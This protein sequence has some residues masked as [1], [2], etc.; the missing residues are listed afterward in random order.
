MF[1]RVL[2]LVS[3][4]GCA[5][6]VIAA[7][8][9]PPDAERGTLPPDVYIEDYYAPP[10]D[11]V[12]RREIAAYTL[13]TRVPDY[14]WLRYDGAH[15]LALRIRPIARGKIEQQIA[16]R[17]INP[18]R[19][20]GALDFA[21]AAEQDEAVRTVIVPKLDVPADDFIE[22]SFK[23]KTTA[24]HA[25]TG[26]K[27]VARGVATL[28]TEEHADPATACRDGFRAY[29]LAFPARKGTVL[30]DLAIVADPATAADFEQEYV[31]IDLMFRRSAPQSRF[32]D[33]PPR[34]WIRRA[35][36]EEGREPTADDAIPDVRAFVES[37]ADE[38]PSL[39]LPTAPHELRPP[40]EKERDGG[41]TVEQVK[42]PLGDRE[43]GALRITLTNGPR[44]YLKFPIAFDGTDYNTL[45]FLARIETPAGARP[46]LGDRKPM[47]WGTDARELNKP[48][49]TFG[50]GVYSATH[51]FEDWGR[52][53]VTQAMF[54]Q[55]LEPAAQAPEGWRVFAYDLVH[56]TPTGNKSAFYPA[57]T[58][59]TFYYDNRKIPAGQQVV[60]TLAAPKVTSGLM[61]AGGDLAAY[62]KFLDERRAWPLVSNPAD[63]RPL[64]PPATNRLVRPFRFIEN[65][66][67]KG[68]VYL[69]TTDIPLPYR[70]VAR[71]AA[72]TLVNLLE[73][74]HGTLAPIPLIEKRP[75]K[76]VANAVIIG[77]TT[78]R[79]IDRAR[80]TADLEALQGTPGCAIRSDGTN[81]YLYA[82]VANY[83]GP[84]RGL[85][86][87]VYTFLENNTDIIFAFADQHDAPGANAVFDPS[88]DGTFDIVWGRDYLNV[89]P[90]KLWGASG[91]PAW[92]NDH[93][94]AARSSV[95]GD[96]EYAGFRGRS[97]NHWWGYGTGS[98]GRKGE[99]NETWGIGEDGK[100][101]LPGCYTGHPC[102]IRVLE[103]AKEEYVLKSGF[104]PDKS[105]F[106]AGEG[107]AWNSYDLHGLWVEDT[108][109]VCQCAACA[110][111]IRLPNGSLVTREEE[112]FLST[113]FY[114]N[115]CAMLNAVNVYARRDARVESIAYFW[116]ARVPRINLS[117][118][119]TV[120]FCPYIRKNYFEPIYAPINDMWWREMVRWGQ[121]DVELELYEYFL[122]I[123]ARPWADVFRHDWAAFA[124]LGLADAFLEGDSNPLGMMERWVVTR[125]MWEPRH[126]VADLRAAFL[127]RTF[128][129]AAP[130]VTRFFTTLHGLIYRDYAPFKPMEFEDLNDFGRLAL[131]TPAAPGSKRTVADELDQCLDEATRRVRNPAAARQLVRF[132]DAW[133]E[134]MAAARKAE[135]AK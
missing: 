53:G 41:F 101:M 9:P 54:T 67:P 2:H 96:W 37:H 120:R 61:Q 79:G 6:A 97:C 82:A 117:R 15:A 133:R 71:R 104:A 65:H 86:N 92:H 94:R 129:E 47:L 115:G 1:Q 44:C 93:N 111:P 75:P 33:I 13:N 74:K 112:E 55:N 73:R 8:L 17:L 34:R 132:G 28:L 23:L 3:L 69:D 87:A 127:H 119:Y 126:E 36:F 11:F 62:R 27:V 58:H 30:R 49:D 88:P 124:S 22:L 122:F 43:V 114:A 84:A 100:P 110:L 52:W 59:W 134:Y 16:A 121:L 4:L 113:Q 14:F 70:E 78:F 95:W 12:P 76:D 103:P 130:E 80:Y 106:P 63:A 107:F 24:R 64:E 77:G 45:T 20:T 25:G 98:D 128:R 91:V 89:P 29:K 39:D 57:V 60:I 68:A 19:N 40:T 108:L 116:M 51:D 105:Q 135:E 48:F 50:I 123:R 118:N 5:S 32:Q 31:I 21:L 18:A 81:V 90:T 46:L 85:A 35:V 42:V 7:S 131:R 99:P 72:T 10:T 109:K 38:H 125:L 102:L 66:M 26:L 83:A 56:G